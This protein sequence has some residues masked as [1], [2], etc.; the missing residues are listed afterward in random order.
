MHIT[1]WLAETEPFKFELE[2]NTTVVNWENMTI[3]VNKRKEQVGELLWN[4]TGNS[5]KQFSHW[6]GIQWLQDQYQILVDEPDQ[7][8]IIIHDAA[9]WMKMLGEVGDVTGDGGQWQVNEGK[10]IVVAEVDI[11]RGL[12]E[13]I[14]SRSWTEGVGC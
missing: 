7:G 1:R 13:V 5:N 3:I 11:C 12:L 10:M 14:S 2:H 6:E 9:R 4:D 8:N